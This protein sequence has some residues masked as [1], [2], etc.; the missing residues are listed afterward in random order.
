M[1]LTLSSYSALVQGAG[2]RS[3]TKRRFLA[4]ITCYRDASETEVL[5][6]ELPILLYNG[7]C[8]ALTYPWTDRND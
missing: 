7:T 1:V 6:L 8:S 4:P 3:V 2:N 5:L